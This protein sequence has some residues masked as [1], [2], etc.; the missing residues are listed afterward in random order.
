L[1][2]KI[3]RRAAHLEKVEVDVREWEKKNAKANEAQVKSRAAEIAGDLATAN[4]GKDSLVAE[5]KDADGN[6]L[7]AIVD[8]LKQKFKGPIF[9]AGAT[10][11]SVSLVASVPKELVSKIQADKL[12]QQIAPIVGGKGGGRPEGA[13]GAGKDVSKIT[14]ALEEARKIL[15]N[16]GSG[17]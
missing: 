7:Q 16:Y 3:D 5:V 9:L 8:R 2:E 11:E 1:L 4:A 10:G 17:S 14:Q 6:L 12:I 15:A 13:R